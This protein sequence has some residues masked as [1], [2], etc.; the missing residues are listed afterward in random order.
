MVLKTVWDGKFVDIDIKEGEVFLLPG[1][2]YSV[3]LCSITNLSN[4]HIGNT[5]HSPQRFANTV[6]LVIEKRRNPEN[7]DKCRWYCDNENCR[8]MLY[9]ESFH[10]DFNLGAALKP[11]M[12]RFY[13]DEKLRTCAKCG[14]IHV[15]RYKEEK[16]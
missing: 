4:L 10:V 2:Y 11:V 15:A 9:E 3:P 6:G 1:M 8:A 13:E 16:K 5:P 12:Q 14:T 7:I